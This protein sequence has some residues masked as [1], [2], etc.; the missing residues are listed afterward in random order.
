[1]GQVIR[2]SVD[3]QGHIVIPQEFQSHL[4]L[5]P[6]MTLLVEK[7][8]KDEVRLRVQPEW[9]T[10]VDKQGVL[11]VKAKPLSDLENVTRHERNRRV[12]ELLQRVGL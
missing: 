1:M 11:V 8:S 7:G 2:V 9:P 12:F 10:L 6:G 5:S 4:R 3:D